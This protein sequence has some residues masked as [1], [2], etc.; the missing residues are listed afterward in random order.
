MIKTAVQP[1]FT[2]KLIRW[3]QQKN[4]RL[5]PWKGEKD[6]YKI[7]LSEI[8][9]QQT[10]VE[11]GWSYYEKFI[12]AFPDVFKLAKAP[13]KKVF[14]L[15]EGLGYYNRCRNLIETAK[16][17]AKDYRGRF[18][19]NYDEIKALKGIGPYTAAAIASFAFDLPYAV[20]DGNVQRV[21]SRYFGIT[22][23]VDTAEGKKIYSMLAMAL[24]DKKKPGIYNQ[25][26]M[27]FGA[28][29]CKPQ[30]PLCIQCVQSTDCVAYT[31]GWVRD[32]PVKE[33]KIQKKNR[34]LHYFLVETK[35]GQLYIRRRDQK[36]IWKNLYELILWETGGELAERDIPSASFVKQLFLTKKFTI[37]AISKIYTQQL[38]HQII[39]GRFIH[40]RIQDPLKGIEGYQLVGMKSL[41]DFPFPKLISTYLQDL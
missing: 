24:L 23:P 25:S 26:I 41:V 16:K 29:V 9:L 5:M 19:D 11:Q 7:W 32:L 21:L 13:E 6:P 30:N 37:R 17:I 2:K 14:K 40:I 35:K 31:S 34:W 12:K 22:T 39:H 18:P 33:K 20:L 28:L 8:I 3:N 15:W 27:D 4:T 10:R 1:D 36:D 38:T